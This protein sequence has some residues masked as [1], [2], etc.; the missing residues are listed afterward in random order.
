MPYINAEEVKKIRQSL[1][2]ALPKFKFSVVKD[3]Y[4]AVR[5]AIMQGPVAFGANDRQV[6]QYHYRNHDYTPE[7]M[8]VLDKI[9][10]A[11]SNAHPRVIESEDAD[12]GSIPNYYLTLSIGKWN[13]PYKKVG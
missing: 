1:K 8:K 2:E 5:I 9:M 3:G 4:S 13:K 6:N 10:E 7:Q 12:Y 11:I